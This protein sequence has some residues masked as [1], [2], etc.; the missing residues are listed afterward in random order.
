MDPKKYSKNEM[1]RVIRRYTVELQKYKFIGPG[2][3]VPGPEAGSDEHTMDTM[4]DTY[5]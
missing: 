3:D 4:K 2:I 5:L 1:E